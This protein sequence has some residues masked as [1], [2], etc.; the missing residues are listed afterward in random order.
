MATTTL[1]GV[2]VASPLD[3]FD[4]NT[5][6]VGDSI[7]MA[8]GSL[9]KDRTALKKQWTLTW[10]RISEAQKDTLTGKLD[11]L[12]SYLF[13]PP[14]TTSTFTVY[15]QHPYNVKAH[16]NHQGSDESKYDIT[17]TLVEA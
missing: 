3:E 11:L 4:L 7:R 10:E 5:E 15:T 2:T 16:K 6:E 1:D 12:T 8:N 17:V 13:S 9:R 14:D